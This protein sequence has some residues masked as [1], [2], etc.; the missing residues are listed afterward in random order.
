MS[1]FVIYL[2]S[3]GIEWLARK[4]LS[5]EVGE[6]DTFIQFLECGLAEQRLSIAR[7]IQ[8]NKKLSER[9]MRHEK[10]G[11]EDLESQVQWLS[12]EASRTNTLLKEKFEDNEKLHNMNAKMRVAGDLIAEIVAKNKPKKY[13]T[14]KDKETKKAIDEWNRNSR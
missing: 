4:W 11:A 1:K 3:Q 8:E 5:E 6:K 12:K 7:Y 10:H 9:L 2:P 13:L 14:K